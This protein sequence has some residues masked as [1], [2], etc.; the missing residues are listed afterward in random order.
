[1]PAKYLSVVHLNPVG[2]SLVGNEDLRTVSILAVEHVISMHDIS[3]ERAVRHLIDT[4]RSR[5]AQIVSDLDEP[6]LTCIRMV[7]GS[8]YY[9]SHDCAD[10]INAIL[11]GDGLVEV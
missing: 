4:D 11:A 2:L 10:V 1:M 5:L 6:S 8:Y 3:C 9:C 7:D